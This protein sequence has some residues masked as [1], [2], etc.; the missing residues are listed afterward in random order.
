MLMGRSMCSHCGHRLA[1][2][3]LVPILSWLSLRGKCRYCHKKIQDSPLT[4]LVTVALF[5]VSYM[6]WPYD[7]NTVG[8]FLFIIWLPILISLIALFIYDLRHMLL[9]DRLTFTLFGLT[10]VQLGGL[11]V[12]SGGEINILWNALLG[13]IAL[14]GFFYLLFQISG[15]S[16]IGG[17]DVKLGLG[18]GILAGNLA[19]A[20]L[21][22]F[23]ASAIGTLVSIILLL[24]GRAS[25]KTQVPFGPFLVTAAIVGQLFG[26]LLIH[27]YQNQFLLI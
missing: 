24:N 25:K 2:R 26:P 23:L 7:F 27:W 12:L 3:D 18:L 8:I 20:L 17:G 4:E 21:I 10:L 9:P 1:A 15:G 6:A 22:L 16:W 19:G 11:L 5:I 14:A 13:V